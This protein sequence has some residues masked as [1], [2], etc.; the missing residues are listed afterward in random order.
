MSLKKGNELKI[1]DNLCQ[2][3]RGLGTSPLLDPPVAMKKK[4]KTVNAHCDLLKQFPVT[5]ILYVSVS[6]FTALL[7][8]LLNAELLKDCLYLYIIGTLTA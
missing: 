8:L 5:N 1:F 3:K 6:W 2:G 4:K 7:I